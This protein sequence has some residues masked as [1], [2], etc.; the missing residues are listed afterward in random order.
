MNIGS[1][2]NFKN[3]GGRHSGL[4]LSKDFA[5]LLSVILYTLLQI[6]CTSNQPWWLAWCNVS[7]SLSAFLF[8]RGSWILQIVASAHWQL[9]LHSR[10]EFCTL[11]PHL[12]CGDSLKCAATLH[13]AGAHSTTS[14]NTIQ[15]FRGTT[16]CPYPVGHNFPTTR[17]GTL[18]MS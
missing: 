11:H 7:L 13:R 18:P 10:H 2:W 15:Q 6:K 5:T 12:T 14:L 4:P 9:V 1:C 8:A 17:R 16:P 3:G